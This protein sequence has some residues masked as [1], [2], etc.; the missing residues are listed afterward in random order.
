MEGLQKVSYPSGRFSKKIS[1]SPAIFALF[2][3]HLSCCCCL[4]SALPL[5]VVRSACSGEFLHCAP[6]W[7]SLCR[8]GPNYQ[9]GSSGAHGALSFSHNL[10]MISLSETYGFVVVVVVVVWGAVPSCALPT[11]SRCFKISSSKIL[12]SKW[13]GSF[14]KTHS[15]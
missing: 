4:R 8:W 12:L 14:R 9:N 2:P 3:S 13:H 5:C 11:L 15:C 10:L 1:S 6:V 7:L